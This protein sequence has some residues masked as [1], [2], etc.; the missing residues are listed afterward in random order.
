MIELERVARSSV[1]ILVAGLLVAA[2]LVAWPLEVA[3]ATTGWSSPANLSAAGKTALSPQVASSADGGMLAAIWTRYDS[4]GDAI[5][6]TAH[7]TDGGG[8]WSSPIGI[9]DQGQS[10]ANPQ[11]S[12]SVDGSSQSAIWL[13]FDGANAI[14]QTSTSTNGGNQW[15]PVVD[16]SAAGHSASNPQIAASADGSKLTAV[17]PWFDGSHNVIQ[18]KTSSDSGNNWSATTQLSASGENAASAQVVSSAAGSKVTAVWTRFDG[19]NNIVQVSTSVDGGAGWS[20]AAD[21][22]ADARDASSPQVSASVDGSK[23]TAIWSR[24]SDSGGLVPSTTVKAVRSDDNGRLVPPTTVQAARSDD[25]GGSWKAPTDVSVKGRDAVSPQ[26]ASS[27]EGT[28]L[29]AT[30]ART[31]NNSRTII[32]S[33]VSTNAVWGSP[34]DVSEAGRDA[35]TPQIASSADGNNITMIWVGFDGV[36]AIANAATSTDGGANWG[37]HADLST[38]GQDAANPQIASSSDGTRLTAVWSRF[39]GANTITQVS[40]AIVAPAPNPTPI[41]PSGDQAAVSNC[42]T[43]GNRHSIPRRGTERLMRPHCKTNAGHRV[44][45]AVSAHRRGDLRNY[46][47][48]CQVSKKRT[49]KTRATRYGDGSRYCRGGSLKIRTYGYRLRLRITWF[50]PKT[51]DLRAYQRSKKY[52]N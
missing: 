36:N 52:A 40:T 4:N 43:A 26:V 15:S 47:L 35:A 17:W 46:R 29:A 22:S 18:T 32:Q 21:L 13:R 2:G 9:S 31:N 37:S 34:S 25:S 39:N 7:S 41:S 27:A 45:V 38:P 11:I 44:G 14:V 33:A 1:S 16:L 51:A 30:W 5:I 10:A 8:T 23:L 24:V 28:K 3:Q 12:T 6:Q 49:A 19:K 48:F 20:L 50:A 42:V